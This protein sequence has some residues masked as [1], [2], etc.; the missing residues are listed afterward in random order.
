MTQLNPIADG[1]NNYKY[2]CEIQTHYIHERKMETHYLPMQH[3]NCANGNMV[4]LNA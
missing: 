2:G 4:T 3:I 1:C